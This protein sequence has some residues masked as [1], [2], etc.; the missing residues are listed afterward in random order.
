MKVNIEDVNNFWCPMSRVNRHTSTGNRVQM[1]DGQ[2]MV[3]KGAVCIGP[4]CMAWRWVREKNPDW[5]PQQPFS[6]PQVY[7]PAD[8]SDPW[9][10]STTHGYC[11]L[12]GQP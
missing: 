8:A 9:R 3:V 2:W 10:P 5:K 1:P 12:A 7:H 6:L 4:Q 11:G